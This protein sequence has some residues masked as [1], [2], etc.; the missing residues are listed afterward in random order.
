VDRISEKTVID[1]L[2][3]VALIE[4]TNEA[5]VG[6]IGRAREALGH[7][8][9]PLRQRYRRT[10]VAI[11]CTAALVILLISVLNP[12][13][14]NGPDS[15]PDKLAQSVPSAKSDARALKSD[16]F[17]TADS[18]AVPDSQKESYLA[19][20]RLPD[21]YLKLKEHEDDAVLLALIERLPRTSWVEVGGSRVT[22]AGLAHLKILKEL[23]R[24]GVD[25][26]QIT[27]EGV[28]QLQALT[29]L[30][31]LQVYRAT[32][33]S[34]AQLKQLTNLTQLGVG[35]SG[36]LT[37]AGVAHLA[38]MKNLQ[39]LALA[40]DPGIG[41]AGL[42]H[43]RRLTELRDLDLNHTAVTDEGLEHLQRLKHLERLN[44]SATNISDAGLRYVSKLTS[45]AELQLGHTRVTDAGL[46]HLAELTNLW[47]LGL[48]QLNVT[49]A[50]MEHL[51][52]MKKLM[53]LGLKGTQVSDAA[54]EKLRKE[55]PHATSSTF[56]A[57]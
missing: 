30:E 29:H 46:A 16:A 32:D 2:E 5:S 47:S 52:L 13:S 43:L 1:W 20:D 22:Y 44:L 10:I 8:Q 54:V 48:Y 9:I 34:L 56:G 49:D 26:E 6:A 39:M 55:L 51:K 28:R 3:R 40:N 12:F 33:D 53:V 18:P 57:R 17:L 36:Q 45:L 37:D 24:V 14:H 21:N 50:G 41:D 7:R 42:S 25:A 4:P 11:G 15:T 38:G 31:F 27:S 35:N 19:F 23:T